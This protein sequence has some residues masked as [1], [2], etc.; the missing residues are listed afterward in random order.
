M[1]WCEKKLLGWYQLM[2]CRARMRGMKIHEN[3]HLWKLA[4][5]VF[6]SKGTW[7]FKSVVKQMIIIRFDSTRAKFN[8]DNYYLGNPDFIFDLIRPLPVLETTSGSRFSY[9]Q[10]QTQSGEIESN[11]SQ[12]LHWCCWHCEVGD[13]NWMLDTRFTSWWL[14]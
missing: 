12:P 7:R 14:F 6:I 13:N 5:H 11:Q 9:Y 8:W 3:S 4:E 1:D 2:R 10:L